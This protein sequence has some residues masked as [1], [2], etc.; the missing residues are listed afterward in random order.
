MTNTR[1]YQDLGLRL[2]CQGVPNHL[3]Y[4][5]CTSIHMVPV[6]NSR[7]SNYPCHVVVIVAC[8]QC[9][10]SQGSMLV[11]CCG[12]ENQRILDVLPARVASIRLGPETT[13]MSL[14]LPQLGA[15]PLS[16]NYRRTRCR[17]MAKTM[18]SCC[19]VGKESA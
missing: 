8:T 17:A 16:M 13:C 5:S 10:F 1:R 3:G 2:R 15:I 11:Q 14:C 12:A 4:Q 7:L 9:V 19:I 6:V 18:V